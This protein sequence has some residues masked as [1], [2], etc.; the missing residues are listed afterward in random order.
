MRQAAHETTALHFRPASSV[1]TWYMAGVK[2]ATLEG[3][4][5]GLG[6]QLPDQQWRT[7]YEM[8]MRRRA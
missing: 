4:T 7:P 2:G 1:R 5:A 8:L 3:A 6:H